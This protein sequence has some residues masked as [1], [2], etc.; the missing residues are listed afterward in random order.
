MG[1]GSIL[2]C[3]ET[4][5]QSVIIRLLLLSSA[6]W[7]LGFS[8]YEIL[9]SVCETVRWLLIIYIDYL[10]DPTRT[11]WMMKSRRFG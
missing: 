9:A 2:F 8:C 10:I 5:T 1:L 6:I 7:K 11:F 4:I 3:A